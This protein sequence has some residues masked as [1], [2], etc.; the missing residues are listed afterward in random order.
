MVIR[1]EA[2]DNLSS[3][4]LSKVDCW[5]ITTRILYQG[6]VVEELR[7]RNVLIVAERE[8]VRGYLERYDM[9]GG[10][11]VEAERQGLAA[12]HVLRSQVRSLT[13]AGSEGRGIADTRADTYVIDY[14][15]QEVANGKI[16]WNTSTT[17]R[18]V[19]LGRLAD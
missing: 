2:A 13:R 8:V 12:T 3:D 9:T 10:R 6:N 4:R 5:G 18:R 14:T 19:G 17:L 11:A 16:V 15:L 7:A 1:P